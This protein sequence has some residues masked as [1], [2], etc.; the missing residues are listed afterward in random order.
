MLALLLAPEQVLANYAQALDEIKSPPA[1]TFE[2]TFAHHG[3]HPES[4]DHRIFRQGQRERDEI[5]GFNGEKLTRPTIRVFQGHR[6]PYDVV[7]LSP[8][9]E[10]YTF[11]YL[12]EFKQGKNLVYA[13]NLFARGAPKYEVTHLVIDG[14]TFL[15][16]QL[17]YRATVGTVTGTGTVMFAK[18]DKYWMPQSATARADVNGDLQTE[19]I[20]W[21]KYQFYPNFPPATF[22]EPRAPQLTTPA[23]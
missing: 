23:S 22:A 1:Y 10:A 15:P 20:D 9:P 6:D 18:T 5:V 4:T 17:D 19:R 21:S 16:L 2:Y 8:R 11:A 7:A 13:F 12:G 3:R 14:K